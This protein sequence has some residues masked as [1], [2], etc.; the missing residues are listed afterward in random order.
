[1]LVEVIHSQNCCQLLAPERCWRVVVMR[2]RKGGGL[3]VAPGGP[4]SPAQ[5]G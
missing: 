3:V 1:L 4:R 5:P 2:T